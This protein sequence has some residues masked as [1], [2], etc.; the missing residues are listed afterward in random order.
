MKNKYTIALGI[1]VALSCTLFLFPAR[2]DAFTLDAKEI[3]SL[4]NKERAG[5]KLSSLIH[6]TAL[7]AIAAQKAH[8][9]FANQEFSHT[10]NGIPF[11]SFFDDAGYEYEY[12]GENLAIDYY[13]EEKILS[14]FMDSPTH[15]SNI[16]DRRYTNIGVAIQDG[17]IHKQYTVVVVQLFSKPKAVASS[18]ALPSLPT[19]QAGRLIGLQ[20]IAYAAIATLVV[21]LRRNHHTP[22]RITPAKA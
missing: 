15:R 21:A 6:D 14:A 13:T 17:I 10:Q 22:P 1:G 4:T 8:A 3:I 16:L 2:S 18:G 9:I 19:N 20:G 7:D 12:A 5:E 11:F